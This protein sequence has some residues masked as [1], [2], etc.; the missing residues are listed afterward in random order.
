M[1]T[2]H[3]LQLSEPLVPF[4]MLSATKSKEH[5]RVPSD[6]MLDESLNGSCSPYERLRRS[7]IGPPLLLLVRCLIVFTL[8]EDGVRMLLRADDQALLLLGSTKAAL[9]PEAIAG[10]ARWYPAVRRAVSLSGLTQVVGSF[11]VVLARDPRGAAGILAGLLAFTGVVFFFALDARAHVHGVPAFVCR[12]CGSV[13]GL[14]ALVAHAHAEETTG[15]DSELAAPAAHYRARRRSGMI[16]LAARCLLA[17]YY[18]FS[19]IFADA[20]WLAAAA[21]LLGAASFVAGAKFTHASGL[22]CVLMVTHGLGSYVALL[23]EHTRHRDALLYAFAQDLSVL[24]SLLLLAVV[25]P[26]ELSVDV[27]RS[28]SL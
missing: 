21:G 13:A 3:P 16:N 26:G 15:R 9:E 1:Y 12:A 18:V 5:R 10:R 22:L 11:G 14:V 20:S 2:V 4:V 17:P 19:G 23:T 28:K 24:G 27:I 25:G 7:S 6:T 8:L